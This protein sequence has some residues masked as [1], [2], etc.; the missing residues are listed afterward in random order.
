MISLQSDFLGSSIKWLLDKLPCRL[1][2][3]SFGGGI[4]IKTA[5]ETVL[6]SETCFGL[7]LT[8]YE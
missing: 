2:L 3:L 7:H 5:V 8:E 1:S 6:I 4:F